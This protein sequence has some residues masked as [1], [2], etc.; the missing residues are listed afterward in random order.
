MSYNNK[1]YAESFSQ[2]LQSMVKLDALERMTEDLDKELADSQTIMTEIKT[3]FDSIPKEQQRRAHEN[4]DLRHE[5]LSQFLESGVPKLL[6]PDMTENSGDVDV[7]N[8]IAT[9]KRYAEDLRKNLTVQECNTNFVKKAVE[10]LDL[11]QYATSLEQ[12]S[13]S[14]ANVK[15]TTE[16]VN[17]NAELEQKLTALCQDVNMFT[18]MVQAEEKSGETNKNWKGVALDNSALSY[19]GIINKLLSDIN[20]VTYLLKN[21]N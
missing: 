15:I 11:T 20:E 5:D 16:A 1:A 13:K 2:Y 6:L 7:D 10:N 21:K 19:D 12:L 8:I 3:I 14:L 4:N 17:R 18:Q 9:M